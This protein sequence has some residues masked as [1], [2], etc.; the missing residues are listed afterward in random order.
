MRTAAIS[1]V[2][3]HAA[4][5]DAFQFGV[6]DSDTDKD[7][8]AVQTS[9]LLVAK[10][11]IA[12]RAR[13]NSELLKRTQLQAQ[14]TMILKQV[15]DERDKKKAAEKKA[16]AAREK[17]NNLV[18]EIDS[19]KIKATQT[20]QGVASARAKMAALTKRLAKARETAKAARA[21]KL[22]ASQKVISKSV[23]SS[24]PKHV[25]FVHKKTADELADKKQKAE[26][27]R[28]DKKEKLR[29]EME[30]RHA[31]RD[32]KWTEARQKAQTALQATVNDK[33]KAVLD[34]EKAAAEEAR[35]VALEQVA[36]KTAEALEN[37]DAVAKELDTERVATLAKLH[38]EYPDL[39]SVVLTPQQ[40]EAAEKVVNDLEETYASQTH[41]RI[42][43]SLRRKSETETDAEDTS[44]PQDETAKEAAFTADIKLVL[45]TAEY[46]GELVALAMD[47]RPR[48]AWVQL[49]PVAREN[50][51][52][53]Q[54]A[55]RVADENAQSSN[56][57]IVKETLVE[58]Q[59]D[60]KAWEELLEKAKVEVA[61][62]AATPEGADLAA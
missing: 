26:Q 59:L 58:R 49:A 33:A 18:S 37:P 61:A 25:A 42:D 52:K 53:A 32:R 57:V 17:T 3:L 47:G 51:E 30:A 41:G 9:A 48:A 21:T 16:E 38:A 43:L 27:A 8:T 29:K 2:L 22:A 31:E 36:L 1:F 44:M 55:L 35:R 46:T 6:K 19:H 14:R 28:A 54:L 5:T 13:A 11:A 23:K 12:E 39:D 60:L 34:E 20:A 45:E 50:L 15:G 7:A 56:D 24:L 4:I 62:E 40:K 10:R